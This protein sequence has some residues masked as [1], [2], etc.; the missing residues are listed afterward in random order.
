MAWLVSGP[1]PAL[2]PCQDLDRQLAAKR[3]SAEQ[4]VR[5]PQVGRAPEAV[6]CAVAGAPFQAQLVGALYRVFNWEEDSRHGRPKSA[7]PTVGHMTAP[8]WRSTPSTSPSCGMLPAIQGG[9]PCL[10]ASSLGARSSRPSSLQHG[11]A[12]PVSTETTKDEAGSVQADNSRA[13][14]VA[15]PSGSREGSAHGGPPAH[16]G[17][18]QPDARQPGSSLIRASLERVVQVGT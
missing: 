15:G 4:R 1:C 2:L 6:R 10:C 9:T 18:E 5:P 8:P 13:A 12:G 16:A 11:P 7:Q 14:S 3:G 17:C